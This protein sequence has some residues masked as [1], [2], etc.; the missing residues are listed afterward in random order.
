M[1]ITPWKDDIDFRELTDRDLQA[2]RNRYSKVSDTSRELHVLLE[3]LRQQHEFMNLSETIDYVLRVELSHAIDEWAV[4]F[5]HKDYDI[6]YTIPPVAYVTDRE[7]ED[8]PLV[9]E[10]DVDT[11]DRAIS[12]STV[13]VVYTMAQDAVEQDA[14]ETVTDLV[15]Q[16]AK[17]L[18]GKQ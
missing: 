12:L 18:L 2:S 8:V 10:S 4:D 15:I 6:A 16:G 1:S 5:D 11:D 14:Y 3:T 7:Y 17:R 9:D 13:P